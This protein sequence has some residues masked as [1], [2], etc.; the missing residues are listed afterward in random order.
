MMRRCWAHNQDV[1][2]QAE[3]IWYAP[4]G[5]VIPLCAPCCADWRARAVTAPALA[6]ERIT[7]IGDARDLPQP[8]GQDSRFQHLARLAEFPPDP[9]GV[10]VRHPPPGR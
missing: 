9:R 1:S 3:Y 5:N 8:D 4:S 7:D 6:A 10:E 2:I